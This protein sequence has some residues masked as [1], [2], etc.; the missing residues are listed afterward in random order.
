MGGHGTAKGT[1]AR[2]GGSAVT[3]G[4]LTRIPAPGSLESAEALAELSAAVEADALAPSTRRAYAAAWR[5]FLLWCQNNGATPLPATSETVRDYVVYRG[6]VQGRRMSVIHKDVAAIKHAHWWA[7]LPSPTDGGA[8][9]RALRGLWRRAKAAGRARPTQKAALRLDALGRIVAKLGDDLCDLRDRAVLLVG[10]AGAL[11]RSEIVGIDIEHLTLESRGWVLHLPISK[12]D[13]R[14]EGHVVVLPLHENAGL[15]PVRALSAWLGASRVVAGS[16]FRAVDR[17][18]HLGTARLSTEAVN[19]IVKAGVQRI[20][21]DPAHY[22]AHSLRAG[23]VTEAAAGGAELWRI[24]AVTR[25]QSLDAVRRYIREE[26]AFQN[27]PFRAMRGE[28]AT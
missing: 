5:G 26:E 21:L 16:V 19:D 22:G 7:E 2:D 25:H 14:G 6:E 9:K 15:C 28:R 27:H 24:A 1:R 8:A 20:G 11:R 12:T 3:T 17:H 23:F 10:F 18:G 13:K 4:A